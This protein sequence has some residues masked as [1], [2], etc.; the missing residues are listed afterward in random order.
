MLAGLVGSVFQA[1]GYSTA[2]RAFSPA[3]VLAFFVSAAWPV[4]LSVGLVLGFKSKTVVRL[5]LGYGL[6]LLLLGVA[7]QALG[8]LRGPLWQIPA[9]WLLVNG[10][11]TTL[12]LVFLRRSL[13]N[14]SPILFALFTIVGAG[15]WGLVHVAATVLTPAAWVARTMAVI[16]LPLRAAEFTV[17]AAGLLLSVPFV[18]AALFF[19]VRLY[20]W[21]WT[22]DQSLLIDA[23]WFLFIACNMLVCGVDGDLASTIMCLLGF[24]GYWLTRSVGMLAIKSGRTAEGPEVL[25]LRRF[26]LGKR[27]ETLFDSLTELWRFV[28]PVRLVAGVDLASRI[29]QPQT[30]FSFVAQKLE[31]RYVRSSQ[32]LSARLAKLAETRDPDGRFRVDEFFCYADTWLSAVTALIRRSDAA[33]MDLR[34]MQGRDKAGGWERE[35]SEILAVMP[36]ER[37]ALLVDDNTDEKYLAKVLSNS[38]QSPDTALRLEEVN[39]IK[40]AG[41]SDLDRA[42][43]RVFDVVPF[44][45]SGARCIGDDGIVS[46]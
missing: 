2:S 19:L 10:I 45:P 33:V 43:Q 15:T 4:L 35:L 37:L 20:E 9:M 21:R 32:A 11:P 18:A 27:S 36:I 30:F 28:G 40:V 7:A 41:N 26:A 23:T 38:A 17:L 24:P 44:E 46:Q 16:G 5:Y 6:A 29:L 3:R 25:V 34:G 12:C 39:L 8:R 1:A 42:M 31:S 13:R 14:V 22:S